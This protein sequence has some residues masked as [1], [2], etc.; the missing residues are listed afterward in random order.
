MGKTDRQ[1]AEFMRSAKKNLQALMSMVPKEKFKQEVSVI[2]W[3]ISFRAYIIN[4]CFRE[5]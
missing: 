1:F 5:K 3:H 4:H 2:V